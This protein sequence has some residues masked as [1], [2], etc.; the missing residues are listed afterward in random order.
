MKEK[1]MTIYSVLSMM[2]TKGGQTLLMADCLRFI[3]QC[4]KECEEQ[5]IAQQNTAN[6]SEE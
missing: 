4:I 2:E 5:E 6:T 3:E 1:F